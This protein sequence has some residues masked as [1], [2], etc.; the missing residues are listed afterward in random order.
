MG[1]CSDLLPYKLL[2]AVAPNYYLNQ[3]W[4]IITRVVRHSSMTNFTGSASD[5]SSKDEFEKKYT[6]VNEYP[7]GW[8]SWRT[9]PVITRVYLFCLCGSWVNV[10]CGG[11]T[12]A[13]L[14]EGQ[15]ICFTLKQIRNIKIKLHFWYVYCGCEIVFDSHCKTQSR[16]HTQT[17]TVVK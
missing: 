1:L 4:F 6:L 5:T 13:K 17:S 2:G 9:R 11:S 8:L 14:V 12:S 3:S 10:N 15:H 7:Q 16:P